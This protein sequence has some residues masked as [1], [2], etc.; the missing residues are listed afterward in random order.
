MSQSQKVFVVAGSIFRKKNMGKNKIGIPSHC[1]KVVIDPETNKILKCLV[2]PNNNSN[3]FQV[4]SIKELKQ[5][6]GYRLVPTDYWNTISQ[7][8]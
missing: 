6:L 2:F 3:T 8:N 5:R 4:V 7:N 1:Y